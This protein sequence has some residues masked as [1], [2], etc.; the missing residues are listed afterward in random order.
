MKQPLLVLLV[1]FVCVGQLVCAE[2]DIDDL[3]FSGIA[4]R[5]HTQAGLL[6]LLSEADAALKAAPKDYGLLWKSAALNYFYGEFYS[7]APEEKKKYF[8]ICKEFGEQAVKVAAKG[9]AG[10]YWLGVGMAKW[11]EYNGILYSL[12][13]ADDILNEMNIVI[14]LNPSYFKGLP[15]A[16]RASVYGLAPAVISVGDTGR[17]RDDIKTALMYGRDYR[18]AYLIC[19][20]VYIAWGEWKNA[21]SLL[22]KGLALPFDERLSVEEKDCIKKLKERKTRVDAELAKNLKK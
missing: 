2:D 11:A 19:A 6:E 12:F 18:S 13:S 15:W 21:S 1:L 20:D 5:R 9:V 3:L 16:I 22:E 17:A 10:H 7:I 8:T 14:G 4:A